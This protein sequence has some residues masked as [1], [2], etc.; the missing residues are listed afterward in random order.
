MNFFFTSDTQFPSYN[1][2]TGQKGGIFRSFCISATLIINAQVF[3]LPH[4]E[5]LIKY[6]IRHRF[7]QIHF[8]KQDFVTSTAPAPGLEVSPLPSTLLT[9]LCSQS[10]LLL[11][12]SS[13]SYFFVDK[14][15]AC[16]TIGSAHRHLCYLILSPAIKKSVESRSLIALAFITILKRMHFFTFALVAVVAVSGKSQV[17]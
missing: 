6:D 13:D 12:L 16:T 7:L 5:V 14:Y 15:R 8:L 17:Y 2:K 4:I 11:Y 3:N 9:H 10:R 1:S